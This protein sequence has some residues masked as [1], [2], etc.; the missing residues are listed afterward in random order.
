MRSRSAATWGL[1]WLRHGYATWSLASPDD[2]G[3]GLD[4]A[5]VSRWLG[6]H[7]TSVTQDLYVSPVNDHQERA[8]AVTKRA[9]AVVTPPFDPLR[10]GREAAASDLIAWARKHRKGLIW[11]ETAVQIVL[12]GCDSPRNH[13]RPTR[14]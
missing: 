6:H 5:S 12:R 3:Y 1:H 9:G 2:G 13:D 14:L 8:R 4:L 7:R 11:I 10:E